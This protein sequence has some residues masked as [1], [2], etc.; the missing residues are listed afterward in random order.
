MGWQ[1]FGGDGVAGAG[2]RSTVARPPTGV[3]A[4]Q[5]EGPWW[6]RGLLALHHLVRC[7]SPPH[8]RSLA[9]QTRR[10]PKRSAEESGG[11]DGNEARVSSRTLQVFVRPKSTSAVSSD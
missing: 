10:S 6:R 11:R 2:S 8:T 3:H 7:C 5:R 9:E 4:R 1:P